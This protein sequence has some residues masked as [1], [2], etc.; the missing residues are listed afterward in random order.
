LYFS[1]SY[2]IYKLTTTAGGCGFA[3]TNPGP[4]LT[5]SPS[6]V[7]P[8]PAQGT[9]QTLVAT[10]NNLSVPA[11]TGVTFSIQGAN[12]HVRSA[13]TDAT[14]KATTTFPGVRSGTDHIV[15]SATVGALDLVSNSATIIWGAAGGK[16][17]T[18]VSLNGTIASGTANTSVLFS[19]G[20]FDVSV[21]PN[22]PVSGATLQFT[23]NGKSCNAPTNASGVA[24][25]SL[26]LPN[27]GGLYPLTVSYAGSATLTA[28]SSSQDVGVVVVVV[29]RKVHGAAGT[30]DL[31]LSEVATNPTTEPRQGPSHTIVFSFSNTVTAAAASITEGTA[32]AGAPTFSGTEVIVPLTGVADRQYVTIALSGVDTGTG[33]TGTASV[34]IGFLMGDVNQNRVV[35][36]ADLGLV[37]SLL[38][39]PVTG[40][41]Y[42]KDI[43]VT[44]TLTVADK[45]LTNS[46]LSQGLPP[47]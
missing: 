5:L 4:T 38:T 42:L 13:L 41:N 1:A 6:T 3:S 9:T 29:S 21:T 17:V 33:P 39:Q 20:L 35:T 25:C 37:N 32:I 27:A 23:L 19:A 8:D 10:F 45:G 30:F 22:V 2:A 14:G 46:N 12:Q 47:P 15:A 24:T 40:A 34:R 7:S 43:N 31:P 44:G 26:T 16:H 11:G 36:V 28:A 18:S